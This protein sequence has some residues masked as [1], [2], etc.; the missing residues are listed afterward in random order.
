MYKVALKIFNCCSKTNKIYDMLSTYPK[1]KINKKVI[2]K[3]VEVH[4]D[5]FTDV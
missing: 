3:V 2:G 4:L 1:R 5:S